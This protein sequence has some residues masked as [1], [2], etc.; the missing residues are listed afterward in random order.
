MADSHAGSPKSGVLFGWLKAAITSV[1]GLVGG[2]CLMYF[3]PL[4]D[5][6]IKPG[7]PLANFQSETDG[8]K[9]VCH[10]R[11]SNSAEGWW[12][13]GDGSALEPFQP[14]Q[15]SVSHTYA[16]PGSYTLKLSV[17]SLFGQDHERSVTVALDQ[18]AAGAAPAIDE[19]QV[20]PLQPTAYAPATFKVVS[21]V[22][23]ADL[24]VWAHGA[25]QPLEVVADSLGKQ[26]R[27]VTFTQPGTHV[28]KL[29]AYAAA[30]KQIVE[31]AQ[32]VRVEPPPRGAVMATLNVTHQAV[33]VRRKEVEHNCRLEL[34]PSAKGDK[35][36]VT[37]SIP[38]EHGY[39]IV[40]ARFADDPSKVANVRSPRLDVL[41]EGRKAQVTCELVK[42]PKAPTVWVPRVHLTLEQRSVPQARQMPQVSVM[43]A[44]PGTTLLPMPTPQGGWVSQQRSLKLALQEGARTFWD[45]TQVPRTD[46]FTLNNRLYRVST[47]EVGNQVQVQVDEV[48][49]FGAGLVGN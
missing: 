43:A 45:T 20:I 34:L 44:V 48:R 49:P 4:I 5:K 2:A 15:P 21:T 7:A 25:D 28:I 30:G 16:R 24:C 13:F 33:H 18:A 26:E 46:Q 31:K 1:V 29:A 6:V 9:V 22:K 27:Y 41:P 32:A 11:S 14:E 19:L 47:T 10:N 42:N 23:H 38:A 8:L 17:R 12:D 37:A 35:A 39:A 40:A 36:S 3:S